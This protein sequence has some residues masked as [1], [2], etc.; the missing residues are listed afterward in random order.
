AKNITDEEYVVGG[1]QFTT[2][3]ADDPTGYTAGTGGDNTLIGY[4]G[5]PFTISLTV[6]Y[7][8]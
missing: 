6:G 5:D 4:Y 3:N 2:E 8:F 7:R 1:Y